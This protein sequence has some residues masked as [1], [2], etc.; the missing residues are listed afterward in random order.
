MARGGRL[1]YVLGLGVHF[2]GAP[3]GGP[4]RICGRGGVRSGADVDDRLPE[5]TEASVFELV[6]LPVPFGPRKRPLEVDSAMTAAGSSVGP[7]RETEGLLVGL[8]VGRGMKFGDSM[9]AGI[10]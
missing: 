5:E 4:T 6:E 9:A 8:L 2:G 7:E 10:F 3:V 1:P